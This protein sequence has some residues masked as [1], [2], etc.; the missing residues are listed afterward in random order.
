M[1][2]IILC[3]VGSFAALGLFD[4]AEASGSLRCGS[5]TIQ[6]GGRHGP[7]RYEVLKK[8]GEPTFK[9]GNV[10]VYEQSGGTRR[11]VFN[12]GGIV[13]RIE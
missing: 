5:Y 4:T 8:C 1:R 10:W 12:Q 11:V 13:D 7:K 9:D 3:V 6:G 2:N